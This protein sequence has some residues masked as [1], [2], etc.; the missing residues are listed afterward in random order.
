MRQEPCHPAPSLDGSLGNS[1]E[2]TA[3]QVSQPTFKR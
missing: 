2:Q 3:W 1:T